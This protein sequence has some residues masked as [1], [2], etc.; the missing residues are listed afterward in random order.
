M[1]IIGIDLGTTNSLAAYFKDGESVLIPNEFDEFLTPSVV[2]L[3]ENNEI[4]VGKTAKERLVSHPEKTISLFKRT[5]GTDKEYKLGIKKYS[6]EELSAFVLKSLKLD[7]E[8]FLK[9]EVEEAVISV[10]AYFDDARRQATKRAGELAGLKVER[11]INEP[12]AAA[13]ACRMQKRKELVADTVLSMFQSEEIRGSGDLEDQIYMI[14]DFGGGTLDISLVECF[15]NVIGVS[16]VSGNNHLGGSDIDDA[17]VREFC[18]ENSIIYN[19]LDI[20]SQGIIK[21]QAEKSKTLLST[22]DSVDMNVQTDEMNCKMTINQEKLIK[23]S[24]DV[25]QE[26]LKPITKVLMDSQ[27][28]MKEID[29][30]VLIGGSGKMPM[31]SKFL[32]IKTG[33]KPIVIGSPDEM[34]AIGIG[35]YAGMKERNEQIKD[36]VMTDICPFTLGVDAYRDEDSRIPQMVPIIERNTVLPC[37]KKDIFRPVAINQ[38]SISVNVYQGESLNVEDN[39]Y[40]GSVEIELPLHMERK[41]PIELR[42]TYDINGILDIEATI[43]STGKVTH[44]CIIKN[45]DLSDEDIQKKKEELEKVK[46][47]DKENAKD[48]FLREQA[49][50]LFRMTRGPLREQIANFLARYDSVISKGTPLQRKRFTDF[51]ENFLKQVEAV[52][53]HYRITDRELE[54][55]EDFDEL[56]D[57]ITD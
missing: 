8:R 39:I 25:L 53:N 5:M 12:S 34:V 9:K 48:S 4:I 23:I 52:L 29:E 45:F 24:K 19:K 16:A 38:R 1:A 32:E 28:S 46:K 22:K 3:D 26:I 57:D 2:S 21:K 44:S 11:I 40:L 36:I 41:E 7:A 6:S 10:P 17:I 47:N 33:K 15:E 54:I 49:D 31:I 27:M 37:T 56:L 51:F 18:I 30:L 35:I 13:L 43:L 20:H 42:M 55:G 50:T 14:F